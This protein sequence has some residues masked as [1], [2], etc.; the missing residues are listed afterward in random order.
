MVRA[1]SSVWLMLFADI[2]LRCILFASS[3]SAMSLR[4][5]IFA[6][7][8]TAYLPRCELTIIGCGSVSEIT[9]SPA[10]PI[11]LSSSS[12]NFVLK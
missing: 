4:L 9:P 6:T 11:K 5:F 1:T 3:S 12:S 8:T 7:V 10:L 2:S